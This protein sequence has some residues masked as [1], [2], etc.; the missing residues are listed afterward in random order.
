MGICW[1]PGC[2]GENV[3]FQFSEGRGGGAEVADRY[4]HVF[5]LWNIAFV[6]DWLTNKTSS[7]GLKCVV[8]FKLCMRSREH[9]NINND[10]PYAYGYQLIGGNY[11]LILVFSV[12]P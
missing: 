4:K 8:F 9:L 11:L 3:S 12:H 2:G 6:S 7:K 5:G 1:L 10:F